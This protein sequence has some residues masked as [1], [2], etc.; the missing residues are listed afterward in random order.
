MQ[1]LRVRG[2]ERHPVEGK[3]SERIDLDIT[4]RNTSP[5]SQVSGTL[6]GPRWFSAGNGPYPLHSSTLF[7]FIF[8]LT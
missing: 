6:A 1:V 2:S 7:S 3:A 4:R 8:F 5:L